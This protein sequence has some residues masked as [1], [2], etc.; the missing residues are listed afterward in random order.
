MVKA[1]EN[2]AGHR[3]DDKRFC[4][5]FSAIGKCNALFLAGTQFKLPRCSFSQSPI[6]CGTSYDRKDLS[7]LVR[8][9]T[10]SQSMGHYILLQT[11]YSFPIDYIPKVC[12]L[13]SHGDEWQP[14]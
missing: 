5:T 13:M 3:F 2:G 11:L 9:K 1:D 7:S 4:D 14:G 6:A 8:Y 10:I 12:F